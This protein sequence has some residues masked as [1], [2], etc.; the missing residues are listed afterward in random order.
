MTS[1]IRNFCY[2]YATATPTRRASGK[3]THEGNEKY[4][5]SHSCWF[6][7]TLPRI[8]EEEVFVLEKNAVFSNTAAGE[9]F[10][11]EPSTPFSGDSEP[12]HDRPMYGLHSHKLPRGS[13]DATVFEFVFGDPLR[14][15]LF[16]IR[17]TEVDLP[18]EIN[19]AIL[20]DTISSGALDCAAFLRELGAIPEGK[21]TVSSM[22][23]L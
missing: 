15:A 9:L 23:A 13:L 8:P 2:A 21:Q 11:L 5:L 3:R 12:R 10:W 22:I 20:K 19:H 18:T 17:G 1:L 4:E 14:A 6:C 16:K 7:A